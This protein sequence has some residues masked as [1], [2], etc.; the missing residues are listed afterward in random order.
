M[1]TERWFFN[2]MNFFVIVL[3]IIVA[4]VIM[5]VAMFKLMTTEKVQNWLFDYS[6][7]TSKKMMEKI[8]EEELY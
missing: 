7:K 6:F 5:T 1:N 3:A 4:N 2:M 8:E